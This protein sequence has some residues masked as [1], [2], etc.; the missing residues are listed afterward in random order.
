MKVQGKEPSILVVDDDE[1]V[2]Q[3]VAAVLSNHAYTVA[4]AHSTQEALGILDTCGIDLVVLDVEI[5][6]EKGFDLLE[7]IKE[8]FPAIHVVMLTGLG[9]DERI[10]QE[11]GRRGA[12]GYV[13]KA[14]PPHHLLMEVDR[15]LR[16][17]RAA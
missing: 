10:W 12:S 6:D 3:T 16:F 5:G 15:W 14:L 11:A 8:T 17:R 2:C 4:E 7:L 13:S 9:Y 1:A